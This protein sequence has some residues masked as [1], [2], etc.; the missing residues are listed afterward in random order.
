MELRSTADFSASV[1]HSVTGTSKSYRMNN[2]QRMKTLR[3]N[4]QDAMKDLN[5]AVRLNS[6]EAKYY[7]DRAIVASNL[8]NASQALQDFQTAAGLY[9]DSEDRARALAYLEMA[10]HYYPLNPERGLDFNQT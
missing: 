2:S 3:H 1:I 7:E 8:F 4:K 6:K 10:K 9:K 5:E